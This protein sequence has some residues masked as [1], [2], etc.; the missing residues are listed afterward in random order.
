MFNGSEL[1]IAIA[2]VLTGAVC[3]GFVLHWLW[4]ALGGTRS[5][6]ARLAE[7]AERL[8]EADLAREAAEIAC[9]TA[10]AALG[11]RET[12]TAEQLAAMQVRLDGALDER[13]AET[14]R[15]L[16]EAMVELETMRDG[17]GNARQ[18]ILELEAEVAALKQAAPKPRTR[19][20][21]PRQPRRSR[22]AKSE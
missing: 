7:M 19:Q 6:A 5:D 21:K 2:M 13:R 1:Q 12:E 18:H 14:E 15:Q 17:L 8:H 4:Q 10:E 20:S 3:F 16:S 9:E 11:R 22:A